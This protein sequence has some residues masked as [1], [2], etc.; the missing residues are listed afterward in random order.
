MF[1]RIPRQAQAVSFASAGRTMSRFG[2][3]RSAAR[4]STGWWVGPSSPR[5]MESCVQTN[6]VGISMSAAMRTEAR[7]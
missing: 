5:P 7:M 1:S 2:M 6:V 3:A 4:C